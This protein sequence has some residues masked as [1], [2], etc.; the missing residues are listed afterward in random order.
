L[1]A[2]GVAKKDLQ[3]SGLSI[4]PS[5]DYTSKGEPRLNGYEVSESVTAKLRDVPRA[6][7]AIGKAV[8]AGGNAVRV[9]QI[10]LDLEG[11]GALVSQARDKA[12]GD[13]KTKAEQ[14][15]KAA[16]RSLGEV[17]SI[18]ESVAKPAPVD[19]SASVGAARVKGD[20]PIQ[21]GSQDVSVTVVVRFSM[22]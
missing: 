12:F 6:G 11:T 3:T 16:G 21:P 18:T 17:I 1:L 7:D 5:Y 22:R 8:S 20:V 13:A 9:N 2:N 19:V 14:Y 15:A 4:S 10:N